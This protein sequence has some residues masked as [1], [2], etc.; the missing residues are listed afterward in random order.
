MSVY[1]SK[2][3]FCSAIQ[4][5]KM[6]WLKQF[7]PDEFDDSV[8]DHNVLNTGTMVG[9]LAMGLFGPFVE[10]PFGDLKEMLRETDKLI[11][12][13]TPIITEASFSADGNF[14]SV[15]ILKNHGGGREG[16]LGH[17]R[18]ACRERQALHP[19]EGHQVRREE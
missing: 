19:R 7:K 5:P 16:Q 17:S 18:A 2:S 11:K 1:L 3:R 10:V 14:C 13:D 12:A 8:M 6:L 9:D 4:C 15:D